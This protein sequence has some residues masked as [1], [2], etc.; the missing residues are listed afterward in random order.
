M[1]VSTAARCKALFVGG[2]FLFVSA[3]IGM[4]QNV[5][6]AA[7]SPAWNATTSDMVHLPVSTE[8][9]DTPEALGPVTPSTS[10]DHANNQLRG[11]FFERLGQF[12][13]QDWKGTNPSGPTPARR[14]LDAPLDSS[15]FPS[16]DWG[17]GGSPLIGTPDGNVY[18]LMTALKLENSRVK[19]YGWVAPSVNFSTS[20]KNSFPVSYDIFP[21]RLE[22]NQ[23]VIYVERLPDTVQK[24]HVDFGFHL[25]AFYGIDY[26]FTTAKDYFSQQLLQKNR[27]YGFDPGF[28]IRGPVSPGKGWPE[29]PCRP[30]PFRARH[31][32]TASPEQL[33]HDSLAALYHRPIYG[34]RHYR[35][36]EAE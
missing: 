1:K 36:A 15:P 26:R 9:T 7:V 2:C 4:A 27:R 16:A 12:Y 34:Y 25:T 24:S 13:V 14:A 23:A 29:Y 32:G 35:D 31:R 33:Q 3:S 11:N 17:Y 6:V 20:D 22:L 30:L 21:N 18:P 8:T 28:G 10:T 5:E 19:V